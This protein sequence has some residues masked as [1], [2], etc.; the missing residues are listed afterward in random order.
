MDY[1]KEK[2][3]SRGSGE[4]RGGGRSGDGA[5]HSGDVTANT[6]A[7]TRPRTWVQ[8]RLDGD[9]RDY[10]ERHVTQ[11]RDIA[12][13]RGPER[14][15]GDGRDYAPGANSPTNLP[16]VHPGQGRLYGDGRDYV[17]PQTEWR[18]LER[19]GEV[20]GGGRGGGMVE[21]EA[22]KLIDEQDNLTG[23]IKLRSA[24]VSKET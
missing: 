14:F 17:T 2:I 5:G 6:E 22:R 8:E 23:L 13:V 10:G 21:G 19:G 12:Q 20:V 11:V 4:D 24:Q 1:A 18:V 3:F 16:R 15:D 9:G 7:R